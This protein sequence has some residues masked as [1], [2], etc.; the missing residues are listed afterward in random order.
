MRMGPVWAGI[1][2]VLSRTKLVSPHSFL[3]T[4]AFPNTV[5]IVRNTCTHRLQSSK[6]RQVRIHRITPL[7]ARACPHLK[8]IAH[9][10]A[11]QTKFV[12][13]CTYSKKSPHSANQRLSCHISQSSH[14][15]IEPTLH[16]TLR[17]RSSLTRPP[18]QL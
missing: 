18:S 4:S 10:E 15:K 16:L 8:D 9:D 1:L 7:I 6:W 11:S 14:S 2:S 5:K 12:R 13:P 3:K 17:V